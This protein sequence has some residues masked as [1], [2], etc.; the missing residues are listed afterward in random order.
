[1]LD[2]DNL[3]EY[4]DRNG[5][6]SGSRALTDIAAI[7]KSNCRDIDIVAKYGGDE[8]AILLPQTGL[9]GAMKLGKRILEAIRKFKFDRIN[10]GLLTCSLGIAVYPED[11]LTGE[12]LIDRADSA[13][14]LAK[15]EGKNNIK[16]YRG[17]N[18]VKRSRNL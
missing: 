3:K 17:L 2:V 4:N 13:L 16:S 8:F 14:Y 11:A 7:L 5:H 9:D 10:S 6:L 15:A 18:Y 12:Q 1:M